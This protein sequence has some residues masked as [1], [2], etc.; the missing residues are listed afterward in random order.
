VAERLPRAQP[1]L[2]RVT[3]ALTRDAPV[4]AQAV[5]PKAQPIDAKTWD[6]GF[7]NFL[8]RVMANAAIG[9]D[10]EPLKRELDRW[11]N[12]APEGKREELENNRGKPPTTTPTTTPKG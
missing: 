9:G 8:E 12:N 2:V 10:P 4:R 1:D 3:D 5:A 11:L 6:N 7:A